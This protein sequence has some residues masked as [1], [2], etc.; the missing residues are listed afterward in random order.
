MFCERL[1]PQSSS[2]ERLNRSETSYWIRVIEN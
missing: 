1:S 2:S